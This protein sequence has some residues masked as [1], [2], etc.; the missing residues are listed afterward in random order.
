MDI[1]SCIVSIWMENKVPVYIKQTL[2]QKMSDHNWVRCC[3]IHGRGSYLA[4]I[5]AAVCACTVTVTVL[6]PTPPPPHYMA[7]NILCGGFESLIYTSLTVCVN[8]ISFSA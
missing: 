8:L 6:D 7:T 4:S 5:A 3:L 2:K 1:K